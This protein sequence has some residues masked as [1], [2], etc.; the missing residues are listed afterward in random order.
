MARESRGRGSF[1]LP[2]TPSAAGG[3]RKDCKRTER[4]IIFPPAHPI[5][6]SRLDQPCVPAPLS[7]LGT[8]A[9]SEALAAYARTWA[10]N[11]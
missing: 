11:V 6:P 9:V 2:L 4:R 5:R 3:P 7:T 8:S 10:K 1:I